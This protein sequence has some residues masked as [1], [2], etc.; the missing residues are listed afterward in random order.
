MNRIKQIRERQGL[1][2]V[3]L[4]KKANLSLGWLWVLENS[5][6]HRVSKSIKKRVAKA[7]GHEYE[8]LFPEG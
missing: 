8:E 3:D 4:A 7:L 1:R 6:S 2:Q 5:F